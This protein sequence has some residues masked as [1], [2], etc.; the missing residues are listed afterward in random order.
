MAGFHFKHK[1][2]VY[3]KST[4]LRRILVFILTLLL[5]MAILVGAVAGGI[6]MALTAVSL[7][8]LERVGVSV[9]NEI[10]TEDSI[11]RELSVLGL[12]GELSGIPGRLSSLSINTLLS[13]YGVIL[14]DAVRAVIPA[15]LCDL[16]LSEL[17]GSGA[18]DV[19]LEN[20]TMGEVFGSVGEQNLPA[21]AWEKLST[22]SLSHLARGEYYILFD[23]LYL[24][25]ILGIPL[26]VAPDG[27]AEPDFSGGQAVSITAYLGT[28]NLG[29]YFAAEDGSTVIQASLD[30]TPLDSFVEA[31]EGNPI[32]G[33]IQKKKLGDLLKL[34][35]GGFTFSAD[36]LMEDLYLGDT[37]S[38][39]KG[40]DG[41]W[42][43][44]DGKEATGVFRELAGLPLNNL[45]G[46]DIMDAV[47]RVYLAELMGYD[48]KE[49]GTDE[50]GKPKY[51]FEKLENGDTKTPE[52]MIAEFADM[53][54]GQ[55]RTDGQL[56]KTVKEM[57][58]GVAM[59]Y[60]QTNGVW[61]EADGETRVDGVL[62]PLLGETVGNLNAGLD[63]LYL[64][65]VMGFDAIY[66]GGS[67]TPTAFR[68]DTNR[69]G[70]YTDDGD[71]APGPLMEKFVD[72]PLADIEEESAFTDR[73]QEVRIGD[74][75]GYTLKEGVWYNGDDP[76]TGMFRTL[77]GK[78]VDELEEA[79][80]DVRVSDALGYEKNT[81]GKWV[82]TDGGKEAPGIL[83]VLMDSTLTTI[84]T[85]VETVYIGEIMGYEKYDRGPDGR[86]HQNDNADYVE[87][88]TPKSHLGFRRPNPA[89]EPG[90]DA[91]K[92]LFPS[93]AVDVLADMTVSELEGEG[94][95]TE[96]IEGMKV[97][98]AMGYTYD[99]E[100]GKWLDKNDDE[101][102][103]SLLKTVVGKKVGEIGGVME[104]LT[105]GEAMGYTYS[106]TCGEGAAC[107]HKGDRCEHLIWSDAGGGENTGYVK[108]IG[109]E[110]RI[111]DLNGRLADIKGVKIGELMDAKILN[112]TTEQ[113]SDLNSIFG[114]HDWTE[115][116]ID[117]FI[118]SFI[119]KVKDAKKELEDLKNELAGG[120]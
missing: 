91:P 119:T 42:Y 120:S 25:D 30:R 8:S 82:T 90:Q 4:L 7:N 58:I 32:A 86:H 79:V 106:G 101:V 112:F 1:H 37:L 109:P 115:D 29:E 107:D 100:S 17:T 73:I 18:L 96:K 46:D 117:S 89:Y 12:I 2:K 104:G 72:M 87:G 49:D 45:T 114:E 81:D 98:I 47:D 3:V 16:P 9:P 52:G 67:T 55:L 78:R 33:A 26:T 53:T 11:L 34:T 80:K 28:V 44:A 40:E 60:T 66:E 57:Q 63:T 108:I 95:I 97:G 5:G 13:E 113:V 118:K 59:G 56:D 50:N 64:G 20:V 99:D 93:G 68:K 23:G 38:Y 92:Y 39:E 84:S 54:V 110:T 15:A 69:N 41:I 102:T 65:E 105:L 88:T 70:D 62:R 71:N 22:R 24:G 21:L 31:D 35:N 85:R 75:M 51:T 19:I 10:L 48:R 77:A 14:P 61:Y 103:N 27:T 116:T 111:K 74:A 36:N 94:K 76:V 6:Y 83:S 43:D